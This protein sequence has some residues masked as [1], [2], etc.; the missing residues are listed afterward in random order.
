MTKFLTH[1][2]LIRNYLNSKSVDAFRM[3][4]VFS[5]HA[6]HHNINQIQIFKPMKTLYTFLAF[7]LISAGMLSAQQRGFKPVAEVT[8][9]SESEIESNYYAL[10][11][12]NNTYSDPAIVSLDEP[13][14]DA[15]K[16]YNVLT[17]KYT[18][19][20]KNVILLKNANYVQMIEA[21][22]NLSSKLNE[23]DNLLIF[24][25]GH[26]WWDEAK[27][28]GYWL[29]VDAKKSNTAFWIR[30]STISDYMSSSTLRTYNYLTI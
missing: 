16:L 4:L 8:G 3:Y 24:Y 17:S 26:G 27:N 19:P 18:F 2:G 14:N 28:L 13:V 15:Q 23:N 1:K 7:W 11:I 25:A 12:G 20:K 29:P 6:K 9:L 5:V 10:I 22:D 21:F 30:N